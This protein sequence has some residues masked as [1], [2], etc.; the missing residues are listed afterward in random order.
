[1]E[2]INFNN[3][4]LESNI[5][6][7]IIVSV[8]NGETYLDECLSSLAAQTLKEIEIICVNDGSTDG[9]LKILKKYAEADPRFKIISKE[10]E[11]VGKSRNIA[12]DYSVGEYLLF[13]DAD[14]FFEKNLAQNLYQYAKKYFCE[15]VVYKVDYYDNQKHLFYCADG[16]IKT[17]FMPSKKVFSCESLGEHILD[18]TMGQAWDKIFLREFIVK[19]KIRFLEQNIFEDA[20]FTISAITKATRISY[21]KDL[22]LHQRKNVE[23]SLTNTKEQYMDKVPIAFRQIKDKLIEY[24]LFDKD[25]IQKAFKNRIWSACCY[26]FN[27]VTGTAKHKFYDMLKYQIIEEFQLK[28]L[29]EDYFF[30]KEYYAFLNYVINCEYIEFLEL[31]V[32]IFSE[33]ADKFYKKFLEYKK[34]NVDKLQHET[35]KEQVDRALKSIRSSWSFRIGR[36]ITFIPRKI[37]DTIRG[38]RFNREYKVRNR[39]AVCYITDNN[40]CKP[41]CVSIASLKANRSKNIEYKIYVFV[42]NVSNILQNKLKS[43]EEKNFEIEIQEISNQFK[44][45]SMSPNVSTAHVNKTALLKFS[46]ANILSTE[47]VVLYVDGDTVIQSDLRKLFKIDISNVYGAMVKDIV[48]EFEWH[49][50]KIPYKDK[51]YFNSGVMLLNLQMLR[52]NNM[53]KKLIEYRTNY[54]NFYMDQDAFNVAFDGKVKYLDVKWNFMNKLL[55]EKSR[56]WIEK[57]YEIKLPKKE[58]DIFKKCEIVHFASDKKPWVYDIGYCSYLYKKYY[59]KS[60]FAN[61]P[62]T[63]LPLPNF[64]AL[65]E[66]VNLNDYFV[67]IEEFNDDFII[68]GAV[69]DDGSAKWPLIKF[70][71]SIATNDL[72]RPQKKQG[73]VI[74]YDYFTDTFYQENAQ[75]VEYEYKIN[76]NSTVII[77]SKGNDG[78]SNGYASF[79]VNNGKTKKGYD[80]KQKNR[81]LN[82]LIYSRKYKMVVDFFYVDL[83]ADDN[84]TIRR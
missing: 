66:A 52:K 65:K 59:E 39:I 44:N 1:M 11:N 77:E 84:L 42:D 83:F 22:L 47:N 36:A 34:M 21:L 28:D 71:S 4:N 10:N 30:N 2:L 64:S 63:L 33:K 81:G 70:P 82:M 51:Y 78:E 17:Q 80:F 62:L 72:I 56:N 23:M 49:R 35:I 48:S 41:T 50:K 12:I 61:V 55:R 67:I 60:P 75:Q 69:K 74:V 40:F 27:T 29:S 31:Q 7:S 9:S 8:Y 16:L 6:V 19:N 32:K 5:K 13:L 68:M 79:I 57:F 20:Y 14:D 58:K 76:N 25:Y 18:F 24:Q 43:M 46:I 53:E 3:S 38:M 54:H 26:Y 15:I 37:R 73:C 45:L